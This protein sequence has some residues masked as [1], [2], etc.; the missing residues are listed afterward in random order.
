MA[1]NRFF[2]WFKLEFEKKEQATDLAAIASKIKSVVPID[3]NFY[4]AD[5]RVEM[6][7]A[8]L[9]NTFNITIAGLSLPLYDSIEANKTTV[10]IW[11]GYYMGNQQTEV[12]EGIVQKKEIKAGDCFY[13]TTLSGVERAWYLLDNKPV[14]EGDKDIP[15]A[16]NTF[17]SKFLDGIEKKTGIKIDKGGTPDPQLKIARHLSV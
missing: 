17:I 4:E 10:K 6:H 14:K 9:A 2:P 8:L 11:L 3:R 1:D 7:Y 5:V 16:D 12:F 15:Y 13:E